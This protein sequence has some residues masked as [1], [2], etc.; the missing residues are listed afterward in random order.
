MISTKNIFKFLIFIQVIILFS[1]YYIEYAMN[2][3][4][5]KLC[6]YQRLPFFLNIAF[7]FFLILNKNRFFYFLHVLCI[8]VVI[9]ISIAFYHVG[10]ERDF[11]RENQVC[12]SK[13]TPTSESDL[14]DQLINNQ[15]SG[16]KEVRFKLFKL[17]LSELN[18]I[19]NI[20]FLLIYVHIIR[21]ESKQKN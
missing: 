21:Y 5:C 15:R 11:F 4:A 2:V 19:A 9:N 17:S 8:S 13:K 14:L 16:C 6:K 12:I 10:I 20:V 3:Y 18:L 1:V 7:L